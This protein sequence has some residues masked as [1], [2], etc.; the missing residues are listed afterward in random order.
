MASSIEIREKRWLAA[1]GVGALVFFASLWSVVTTG[2]LTAW[3]APVAE[4]LSGAPLVLG[5][6]GDILGGTIVVASVVVLGAAVL[7]WKRRFWGAARLALLPLAGE[8]LTQLVKRVVARPRPVNLYETGFSF[9]SGH[10]T[11]A[12]IMACLLVWFAL[13][14]PRGRATVVLLVAL[15]A[16]WALAMAAVRIV[17]GVHYFTDV[18]GGLGLGLAVGGVGLATI[19]V[20]ERR[21]AQR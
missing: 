2:G 17:Y 4:R 3:D 12:A 21:A 15:G 18:L 14:Q 13:R 20:L 16:G 19:S 1:S 7:V 10:A 9:P 11:N 5:Q 8:V 6:A